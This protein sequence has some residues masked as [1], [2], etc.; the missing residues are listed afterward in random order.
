LGALFGKMVKAPKPL[1]GSPQFKN[2]LAPKRK[3]LPS[4]GM[5][6]PWVCVSQGSYGLKIGF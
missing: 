6:I 1:W 4:L 2:S 3:I 5:P